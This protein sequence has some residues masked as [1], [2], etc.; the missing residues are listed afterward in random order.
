MLGAYCDTTELTKCFRRRIRRCRQVP[1]PF[2][3]PIWTK[4]SQL[5]HSL[6]QRQTTPYQVCYGLDLATTEVTQEQCISTGPKIYKFEGRIGSNFVIL[7]KNKASSG[8]RQGSETFPSVDMASKRILV[9]RGICTVYETCI[10]IV[11][12]WFD[13]A[14]YIHDEVLETWPEISHKNV[15]YSSCRRSLTNNKIFHLTRTPFWNKTYAY[16]FW[17]II[18]FNYCTESRKEND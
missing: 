9:I 1:S 7:S 13:T 17:R 3:G 11:A 5:F 16:H 6:H 14:G 12:K 2:W 15:V 10:A 8:I 18:V 4:P